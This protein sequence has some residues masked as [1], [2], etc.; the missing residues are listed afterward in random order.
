MGKDIYHTLL[1]PDLSKLHPI[2]HTSLLLPF[3]DPQNLPNRIGSKAPC[4]PASQNPEFGEECDVEA[5]LGYKF[6][7]CFSHQYLVQWRGGSAAKYFWE[8]GALSSETLHPYL[9]KIHE[10]VG[11]DNIILPPDDKPVRILL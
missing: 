2:F 1:P 5:L 9:K 4:G 6:M 11:T 7:S 8:T 10:N 3:V